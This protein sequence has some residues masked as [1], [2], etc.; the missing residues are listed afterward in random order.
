MK[1]MKSL[2]LSIA[3]FL[4]IS[5]I[6]QPNL[7]IYGAQ[8][9][10]EPDKSSVSANISN[11]ETTEE[12]ASG[13]VVDITHIPQVSP[14]VDISAE[15]AE[16]QP[17]E[18]S[19]QTTVPVADPI[20]MMEENKTAVPGSENTPEP[21][22][23]LTSIPS[24]IPKEDEKTP[25]SEDKASSGSNTDNDEEKETKEE[26]I[27]DKLGDIK[28]GLFGML[29]ISPD[30]AGDTTWQKDFTYVLDGEDIILSKYNGNASFLDIPAKAVID[31]R[32][33]NS[34]F[35][36]NCSG[37]FKDKKSLL[38]IDLSK[39]DSSNVT[40]MNSMFIGC[41]SLIKVNFDGFDTG[42]VT[43][44]GYMFYGCSS[45]E[46]PDVGGFNTA[47]V[48]NMG[49]M[50]DR[51]S[52]LTNLDLSNFDT[53]N[54]TSM[55]AM[56]EKCNG[57]TSLDISSFDTGNVGDMGFMFYNCSGLTSLDVSN[58]DTA[59]ATIMGYMFYNCS[60]LT[61][62]DV[63][64]FDTASV[65]DMRYMFYGCNGLTGLDLSN[66]DTASVTDMG[67]MFCYCKSL[68]ELDLSGF[69]TASVKDMGTMFFECSSLKS[70][71]LSHFDT[72]NLQIT[73]YMFY[74]CGSLTSLDL[75]TFDM[76]R[77]TNADNM[78]DLT[79]E[80][81]QIEIPRYVQLNIAL[82]A[83]FVKKTN[84]SDSYTALPKDVTKSFT[85]I[86]EGSHIF[87]TGITLEPTEKTIKEGEEFTIK[88]IV[89]PDD[90]S[91]KTVK[92]T[93]SSK[94]T[95]TVDENGKVTGVSAGQATITATTNDGGKTAICVVTVEGP[96]TDVTGITVTP[97]AKTI[98][99]GDDFMIIPTVQPGD[100]DDKT[101]IWTSNASDVATVDG[102]G[103]VTGISEGEATITATT[104]DGGFTAECVVTVNKKKTSVTGI[105]VEPSERTIKE[106][107]EFV[108][109]ATVSP[110]NADDKTVKWASNA[111]GIA[112]V[113]ENGKVRG[114]AVGEATITVTTNDGGKKASCTVTVVKKKT[115]VTGI[116]VSP[117]AR[118]ITED[119]EFTITATVSPDN[120]TDKG[121]TWSSSDTAV[122]TVDENGKVTGISAGEAI[123]TATTV[124]G[125]YTAECVVTV[126]GSKIDVTGITV[127]PT[128]RTIEEN[129]EFIIVATIIPDN[130]TDK[131][132]TFTS[133]DPL[134]AAVD[135]DGKVTGISEGE[136]TII[137]T[138]NDGNKKARCKVTVLKRKKDVTG[139]TVEP[140]S[141]TINTGEE[142]IISPT[143]TPD[144]AT[145]K[146]VT[147]TSSDTDIA[148][149]DRDGKV[150]GKAPGTVTI[151]ATTNDGGFTAGC[152]VTVIEEEEERVILNKYDISLYEGDRE[153]IIATVKPDSVA[154]KSVTWSSSDP[155]VATVDE[156]GWIEA[157]KAGVAVITATSKNG[158]TADCIVTVI[159][160]TVPVESITAD[161]VSKTIFI[162]ESFF[163][164]TTITPADATDKGV[165]WSSDD[166]VIASVYRGSVT[167]YS[168]GT[169]TVRVRTN[170][171]GKEASCIVTVK[172]RPVEVKSIILDPTE[173]QIFINETLPISA[174]VLPENAMD[175]TLKWTTNNPS[176]ATV[177]DNGNVRGVGLGEAVITAR[178]SNGVNAVCIIKVIDL[179]PRVKEIYVNPI[180]KT[181]YKGEAFTIVATVLPKDAGVTDVLWKSDKPDIATVDDKGRVFGKKAGEAIITAITV[182]GGFTAECKVTVIERPAPVPPVSYKLYIVDQRTKDAPSRHMVRGSVERLPADRYLILRDSDGSSIKPLINGDSALDHNRAVYYDLS[183]RDAAG[184]KVNDF[185]KCT[186]RIPLI[187][188]MDIHNGSVRVVSMVDDKLDRSISSST[189]T[190]G[191]VSYVTF[192]TGHFTDFAILY[193]LNSSSDNHYNQNYY[194]S[195]YQYIPAINTGMAVNNSMRVLDRV[196]RT[197]EYIQF[198]G[199]GKEKF[200]KKWYSYKAL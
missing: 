22:A 83:T 132:V 49:F 155:A 70:L 159:S 110:N 58:F 150:T 177:D 175:K 97:T 81:T 107:E 98:D 82:P 72:G 114:I 90:A 179:P 111:P 69:N 184:N 123:I 196:P 130:A 64:V 85:I 26:T 80:L 103:K 91:D 92:W 59:K 51:C 148:V 54:V 186:I 1:K 55:R 168:I 29:G 6:I 19:E 45:L 116:T 115:D 28:S 152:T 66:F 143:V 47:N 57:L 149:V 133:S 138:T 141:K 18:P 185:G 56:F 67:Y 153:L 50:F 52:S 136:A 169:T 125:G 140:A 170:D 165:T 68:T 162:G 39:V 194:S 154:D 101:V 75:S 174:K 118:T 163:I 40:S 182:D 74:N 38:E 151:T 35:H 145:D 88:P 7:I 34:K 95:A 178:A 124:D 11:P 108:I 160:R 173:D 37:F 200:T 129:E 120:A 79:S 183:L 76:S 127:D 63:S 189:G 99:E 166:P 71:D 195:P 33:Y 4:I 180:V 161:P 77:I 156:H 9:Q 48:T 135:E 93:T 36:S 2:R 146:S 142:F 126:T 12:N 172:E 10:V 46:S 192:S 16:D 65:T 134:V 86:K 122:A 104:N 199:K 191:D 94:K 73:R 25:V 89:K 42:K 193:K 78:F 24:A 106:D 41:A 30:G 157:V 60:G 181:I 61:S 5:L 198:Y 144:D 147:W 84:P 102:N 176:V 13:P 117:T 164:T 32:E 188:D 87:V 113:D 139:I 158:K 14:K 15:P 137:A 100:A 105:T 187:E 53:G 96:K 167:G 31:G 17:K 197:G 171:G 121:V 27:K 131:S 21:E 109:T 3:V 44:M 8:V 119:E 112:T 62:L 190:E 20:K 128:A 43:D 23:Q